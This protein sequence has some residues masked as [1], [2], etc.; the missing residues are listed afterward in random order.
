M[1]HMF[2]R[3]TRTN[4]KATGEGY[5]TFRLVRG[6][7]IAGKVRQIT[8]L[9]LGRHFPIAQDDWA[10]LCSRLEQLLNPQALLCSLNC[11]DKIER[12]AQRY[13]QQLVERAPTSA[14]RGDAPATGVAPA[15]AAGLPDGAVIPTIAAPAA[16]PMHT[17]TPAGVCATA[18]DIQSVD[19]DSLALTQPRSVGVEHVAL[20]AIAQLGLV[21]KLTALG[22]PAVGRACILG[23]LIARM[24]APASELASWEWLQANSALGEL[25]DVDFCAL[26]HMRLYRASDALMHHRDT[27]ETHVF[28]AVTTLFAIQETVTLYDLTN[29]YFEGPAEF[30][31]K[32]EHGHSKEKRSDC[33]LVTLGL[34]LDGSGFVRRSKTFEGNINEGPTLQVMLSGLKAPAGALVIMDAGIATQANI[35]WLIEHKYHYLVVR[36]GGV[37][38]FDATQSVATLTAGGETVKL[39]KTT[40]ADGKEVELYCHS[41]GRQAKEV[42]M[43]ERFC[44]RFEAGLQKLADGLTSARGEKNPDKLLQR[45]GQLKAKSHG[46]SQHYTI[47]LEAK[48]ADV[49]GTP[50]TPPAA[51]AEPAPAPVP[52]ALTLRWTKQYVQGTMASHPGVYCLRTNL[53]D[54]D[55][56]KLWHTYS[57]LTDVESVFRSFKGELGLRP[58]F[59]Q[60]ENRADGHLFI[61]VLAYQC[62]QVIRKTLKVHG[63]N[64]S[65]T[66]LRNTLSV[67][68]RITASMQRSD[69]RTIHIRKATKPEPALTR[70]YN[71]LGISA[72]PGGAKK[73][74]V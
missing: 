11:S 15:S 26:S 53:L 74:V 55:A 32:A 21:E 7:R 6:E 50:E 52:P 67:Q 68:Q 47:T 59:H 1:A 5:F 23:N 37:R 40:S 69:G 49:T 22:V 43:V 64:D 29:T 46:I 60:N 17:G 61:T 45:I 38:Q 19:V 58:V 20:Y 56:Q 10:L 51:A 73:L 28:G 33:P 66:S 25:L 39:Q 48:K 65:W 71:A 4:N 24:A 18:P 9:N 44:K 34:V 41:T 72:A 36:R 14:V 12:A 31:D 16:A 13:Y 2:I 27:I 63:I 42:A 54:W 30:N 3:K 62:V 35:D 70:I 8:V 57:T